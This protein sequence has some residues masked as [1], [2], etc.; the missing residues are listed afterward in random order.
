[1]YI[2][3]YTNTSTY[4]HI[5]MYIHTYIAYICIRAY[6]HAYTHG[7]CS[8]SPGPKV[9][10]HIPSYFRHFTAKEESPCRLVQSQ[11]IKNEGG[12]KNKDDERINT[13]LSSL[14]EQ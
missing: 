14:P 8:I 12:K 4:V 1:M 11:K 10:V 9:A 7:L 5:C 2:R 13:G 3:T 6:I